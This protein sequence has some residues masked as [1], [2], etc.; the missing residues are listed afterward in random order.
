MGLL[1]CVYASSPGLLG[2]EVSFFWKVCTASTSLVNMHAHRQGISQ[3]LGESGFLIGL[4]NSPLETLLRLPYNEHV[5]SCN[6]LPF[7]VVKDYLQCL[8]A[9]FSI[10][11]II[12]SIFIM[13]EKYFARVCE[14]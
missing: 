7:F 3:L 11:N 14:Q 13:N 10:M 1:C 9:D 8:V 12:L 6:M 2:E 4:L 5:L